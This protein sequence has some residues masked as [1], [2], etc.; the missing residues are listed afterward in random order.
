VTHVG[1]VPDVT[2]LIPYEG[3]IAKRNIKGQK[4]P[5]VPK[6]DV[7]VDGRSAHVHANMRRVQ[8]SEFLFF[9]RQGVLNEQRLHG[10][11]KKTH[12]AFAAAFS[13][14]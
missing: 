14:R 3:Q 1:D 12:A 10:S 2:H 11:T 9:P 7:A 13:A 5:N 4:G 8:G 6:V